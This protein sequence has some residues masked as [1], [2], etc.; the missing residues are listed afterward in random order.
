MTEKQKTQ[1]K[2]LRQQGCGYIKIAQILG[3]SDNTVK[4]FCRR[5]NLTE[6]KTKKTKINKSVCR[7]CGE[8]IIQTGSKKPKSFCCDDCRKK[9]WKENQSKIN[10]KTAIKYVCTVC[11]K[12]FVDYARNERKYCSFDCYV[13]DR[14]KGGDY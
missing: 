6:V 8:V 7:Q 10:R 13:A 1:I 5:N 11:N 14:Y 3:I 2:E 9:Y 12:T 4:S